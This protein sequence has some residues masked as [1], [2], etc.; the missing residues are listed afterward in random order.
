VHVSALHVYPVKAARAVDLAC[1][2]LLPMGLAHDR[3]WMI[4]DES[5]QF[6]TQRD[7][8]LLAQLETVVDATGGLKLSVAGYFSTYVDA[9][10]VDASVTGRRKTVT[11]WKS[12]LEAVPVAGSISGLLTDWLGKKIEL[13]RFPPQPARYC[14]AE[15]V[16]EKAPV[17]FADGYPVLIALDE[18]LHDLNSRMDSPVPMAR[19]RPNI[20]ISGAP[21]WADDGW[22][23]LRIGS[24][25]LD[26][27][28]P[29]D[30]CIVT[31]TDQT[32]GTRRGPEPLR[33]LAK[34]R[35]TT[36]E[37]MSGVCFGTNAVPRRCGSIS[38]GDAVEVLETRPPW[39]FHP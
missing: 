15:W 26:L 24:V 9:P 17:G 6:L 38:V 25:E 18:S 16:G 23:K 22:H 27:V 28:K 1:A 3:Q 30:R 34:F 37:G 2:D 4:V 5:G 12:T 14:N 13:V 36:S 7:T 39:T 11:V 32:S 29:C 8:P 33:T 31:T 19:F 20:V 35:R 10:A 21:A